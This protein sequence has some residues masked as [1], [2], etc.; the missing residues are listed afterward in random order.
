MDKLVSTKQ[1]ITKEKIKKTFKSTRKIT[2]TKKR[3]II[4]K[5]FKRK[6]L[7]TFKNETDLFLQAVYLDVVLE[8][9]KKA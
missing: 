2:A 8:K 9:V 7:S 5:N 1:K 6:G 3:N 4:E